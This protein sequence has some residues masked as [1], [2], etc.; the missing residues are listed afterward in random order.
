MCSWRVGL[1]Q[2]FC[3]ICAWHSLALHR[4]VSAVHCVL[5]DRY[6]EGVVYHTCVYHSASRQLWLGLELYYTVVERVSVIVCKAFSGRPLLL[7]L[8]LKFAAAAVAVAAKL[9]TW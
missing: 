2:L 3:T 4:R 9:A 5:R 7:L 1:P 6:C 8:L